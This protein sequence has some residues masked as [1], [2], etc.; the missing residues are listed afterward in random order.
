MRFSE[1]TSVAHTKETEWFDPVLVEDT[2]LYVDPF[3]VFDEVEDP[4]FT[5]ARDLVV[6]FFTMC[7]DLLKRSNG[8]KISPHWIKAVR[9]LTFPEP[10]EFALGLSMGSPNGSG[11]DSFFAEQMADSLYRVS[12][13]TE[14]EI[15]YVELFTLFV[16]GLGTDRISDIFCNIL[17]SR[18]IKYTQKVCEELAIETERIRV[19]NAS[20]STESLRWSD[21]RL[22]MPVSPVT[23]GA[24]LL[25][26]E[27]FLQS[28]PLRVDSPGFWSWAEVNHNAVLREDLNYDLG[29]DLSRSQKRE[30]G[31]QLARQMPDWAFDYVE[32]I[33]EDDNQPAYDAK[34]DSDLL[35]GWYEAGRAAGRKEVEESAGIDQPRSPQELHDWVGKLVDRFQ[36]AVEESDLWRALWD[37]ELLNPRKE[38]IVQAIAGQLWVVVCEQAGVDM[39]REPNIGR[40]PVDFKFSAGWKKR[41]LLEVKLMSSKK[42][43]R[44]AE[45]QLPQYMISEKIGFAYYVCVGYKDEE[46][47]QERM[48]LVKDTCK[49]YAEQSGYTVAARFI[50]ARPKESASNL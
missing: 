3:L 45:A 27:R 46:L 7:R 31:H 6:T 17:K 49:A 43:R 9:L 19:R 37:D 40:G 30:R 44:G 1:L 20:W 5:D 32:A 26:P 15:D 4:L 47:S 14:R 22:L 13:R 23:K 35:I 25:T 33:A 39:S 50:D 41:V 24:I 12:Q 16:P 42:L 18:F 11:T 29:A 8:T 48:Q 34:Q 10:K 38:K 2:P 28:I 21:A 36:H